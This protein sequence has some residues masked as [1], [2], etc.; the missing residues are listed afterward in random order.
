MLPTM[1]LL[2]ACFLGAALVAGCAT[3]P[4]SANQPKTASYAFAEPGTTRLG[5]QIAS[6][7]AAHR[8]Q[9]GVRLVARGVDGLLLRTQIVRAAERSL[10]IQ[11]FMFVED[12]TGKLLLESVLRAADRGVRVRLLIDDLNS[13]QRPQI[14]DTLAAL[15]DHRNIEIRLFNPLQYR[16]DV[17]LL[18]RIDRLVSAP[19]INHRMHNKL[20]LADGAIAVIGGRN[21]SDEYFDTG[22]PAIR[23]GDLDAVVIGAVVPDLARS[24]DDFWNSALAVPAEAVA[25]PATASEEIETR[26]TLRD[27]RAES[28]MTDV[29]RR[30]DAG[31]PLAGMLSG[32]APFSWGRASVI[33]DPAERAIAPRNTFVSPTAREL[34][35][36]MKEVT[37]E[38]VIIS[39]YFIPGTAG[40]A[41]IDDLRQRNVRVRVL[42]NSLASTDVPMVHSAY[43]RYRAP[44]IEA[45]V[46]IAE[47]RPAPGSPQP[48]HSYGSGASGAPFAL[49]AKAYVFDRQRVFIGSANL[50]PRSL[51]L[52]TEVGIV[53]DSP[54]L[55][56]QIIARFDEF[57]ASANSYRVIRDPSAS[58]SAPLRWRT[59]VDGRTIEWSE[60]PDTTPWQ[61]LQ[62]DLFSM[63]P[64][65]DQL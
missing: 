61:R 41:T 35:T 12:H 52:N 39:P 32:R 13:F 44:L 64:I 2:I 47:V 56:R 7:A 42:T 31:D 59:D 23:F 55:A 14:Q 20:L 46:E 26:Q 24:F 60:E 17:A 16:G 30:L 10:D 25:P 36:R 3:L 58:A 48:E 8:D 6:Q 27:S 38:L 21:V 19:R 1:R 62:V 4:P 43:R 5:Q 18:Q 9:S 40:L 63:L 45:G 54:D 29:V 49:H 65:E 37:S 33:A 57:S 51:E 50:D 34:G 11:Y 28:D 15:N 22:T 53:I